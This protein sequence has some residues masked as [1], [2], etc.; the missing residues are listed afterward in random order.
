M[1]QGNISQMLEINL[2]FHFFVSVTLIT[3]SV[4]F[5]LPGLIKNC[6]CLHMCFYKI[7]HLYTPCGTR[8]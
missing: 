5:L 1:Y 6:T 4:S 7:C 3:S 8:I 2:N